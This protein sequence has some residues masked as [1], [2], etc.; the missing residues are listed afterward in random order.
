MTS[1]VIWL[2]LELKM[3]DVGNSMTKIASSDQQHSVY[4]VGMH[5]RICFTMNPT[6]LRE[7]KYVTG[8][9][10]VVMASA[11]SDSQATD[12]LFNAISF[13]LHCLNNIVEAI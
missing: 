4:R 10:A 12:D 3:I 8:S 6:G 7:L 2:T 5:M 9:F 13:N 1:V 11:A